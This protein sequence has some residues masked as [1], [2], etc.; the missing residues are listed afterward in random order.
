MAKKLVIFDFDGVLVD[1]IL[2][3]YEIHKEFNP[4][5]SYEEYQKLAHGNFLQ[6]YAKIRQK[7]NYI[8]HL[9]FHDQ[10]KKKVCD[11]DIPPVLKEVVE[12]LSQSYKLSIVSSSLTPVIGKYLKDKDILKYFDEILGFDFHA[13]KVLKLEKIIKDHKVVA[14]DVVFIT[15]TLSDILEANEV[16]IPTIA[17][18]WGL[19]DRATFAPGHPAAVIDDPKELIPTIERILG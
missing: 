7:R 6:D 12:T 13:S 2:M 16:G 15:D 9:D 14:K 19:H 11:I 4:N 3:C 5:F 1:T 18:S 8:S 10:Y 17:V